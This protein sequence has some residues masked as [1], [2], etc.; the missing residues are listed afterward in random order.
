MRN[1]Q[2]TCYLRT[3]D[4]ARAA[5]I[6]VNTVR[7]Y[8]KWGLIPPVERNSTGYRRFTQKHLE[9]LLLARMVFREPYPGPIL[10]KSGV[11]IIQAAVKGDL[12]GA[13]DRAE[14]YRFQVLAELDEAE[15]AADLLEQWAA[16]AGQE[17][18]S[19]PV[20]SGEAAK[21]VNISKDMLRHWERSGLIDAP[22]SSQNRYR[23]YGVREIERLR[24]IRMLIQAGYST[25]AIL[26]MLIQLDRG[27]ISGLRDALDTPQPEEDIFMAA[28]RWLSALREQAEQTEKIITYVEGMDGG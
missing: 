18:G 13:L 5:G 7:L 17:D 4:L 14:E 19:K 3:C 23:L 6:H 26:R 27:K 10:R 8:E 28:D 21:A 11:K 1:D 25:M 12:S 22:R 20:L 24:I 2:P 15:T 16:L 9:C